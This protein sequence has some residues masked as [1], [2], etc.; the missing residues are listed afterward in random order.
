MVTKIICAFHEGATRGFYDPIIKHPDIFVPV[1]G[2]SYYYKQG[3]DDF[4]DKLIRDDIGENISPLTIYINEHSPIYW[5]YKNYNFI[6]NPDMIG[7]CHYRRFMKVDYNALDPNI[8][9]GNRVRAMHAGGIR[10]T[11]PDTVRNTY[12]N[13]C[14]EAIVELYV[15]AFRYF[16]PD[17]IQDMD[18]VL[19]D[20]NYYAKNMFIMN[21]ATFFEFMSFVVRS[22]R[23]LFDE[24]IFRE[25]VSIFYPE[26]HI[27]RMMLTHSRCRGFIMEMFTAVWFEHQHRIHR[28]VVSVPLL[29]FI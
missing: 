11:V 10:G 22:L 26:K 2:G 23:I 16:L 15:D 18:V 17:Y 9:Y 6:G 5:A 24:R 3:R 8:V 20:C 1:L 29:E 4:Y 12:S 13:F 21:R 14:S 19:D 25:A 7:L 28:N 27:R